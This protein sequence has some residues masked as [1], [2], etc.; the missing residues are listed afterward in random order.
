MFGL[1]SKKKEAKSPLEQ[2]LSGMKCRQVSFAD[3]DFDGLCG[4]MEKSA[5]ILLKLTPVNYYAVKNEYIVAYFYS[6]EGYDEN[7]VRFERYSHE[8]RTHRS[9][10]YALDRDMLS[11]ALAKVG[12]ILPDQRG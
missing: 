6:S 7:Y 8:K 5:D 1:F 3:T 11:K 10:I 12:I 2:K 9:K 4:D